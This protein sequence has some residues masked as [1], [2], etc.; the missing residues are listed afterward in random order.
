MDTKD[1]QQV[2]VQGVFLG[3]VEVL[4]DEAA[5]DSSTFTAALKSGSLFV[6]CSALHEKRKRGRGCSRPVIQNETSELQPLL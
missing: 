6:I 5:T 3:E 1:L 2:F 4:N